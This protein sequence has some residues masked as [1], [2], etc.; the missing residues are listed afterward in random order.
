MDRYV[1][2]S[3]YMYIHLHHNIYSHPHDDMMRINE[4]VDVTGGL[5][6]IPGISILLMTTLKP[7][8]VKDSS[9]FVAR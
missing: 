7:T 1:Y 4:M 2:A 3:T 9:K 6:V 5:I 8:T